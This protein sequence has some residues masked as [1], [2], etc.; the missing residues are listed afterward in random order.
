MNLGWCRTADAVVDARRRLAHQILDVRVRDV[1]ASSETAR[2]FTAFARS[3]REGTPELLWAKAAKPIAAL[4][5]GAIAQLGL[6]ALAH[7]QDE[8][9][10]LSALLAA[11]LV[12]AL[13][14]PGADR[15]RHLDSL[16]EGLASSNWTTCGCPPTCAGA[17][18]RTLR[19]A[20]GPQTP[21]VAGEANRN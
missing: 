5:R 3:E 11:E 2:Y 18:Y 21:G 7:L 12:F 4:L 6:Q 16:L 13:P 20:R 15:Q 10:S 1:F 8:V 9:R 19:S 14:E 17:S